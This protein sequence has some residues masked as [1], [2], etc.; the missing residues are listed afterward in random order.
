MVVVVVV[1]GRSSDRRRSTDEKA[2]VVGCVKPTTAQR[3]ACPVSENNMEAI[4][5]RRRS[6]TTVNFIPLQRRQVR[7]REVCASCF[8]ESSG[9]WPSIS[10]VKVCQSVNFEF[11]V[12]SIL[13]MVHHF[14]VL[15]VDI[16]MQCKW[17]YLFLSGSSY[18]Y[19]GGFGPIYVHDPKLGARTFIVKQNS[20][21]TCKQYCCTSQSA[22]ISHQKIDIICPTK[23]RCS[24]TFSLSL[25]GSMSIQ[26]ARQNEEVCKK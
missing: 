7:W 9:D 16:C 8:D 18:Q 15:K 3:R 11:Y 6:S 23:G 14:F 12:F 2:T 17:C 26:Q 19:R 25:T 22:L 20:V 10:S 4:N 24:H 13:F 1:I 5:Q 21:E